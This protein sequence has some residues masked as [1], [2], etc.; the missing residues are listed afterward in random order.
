MTVYLNQ[1]SNH[2]KG[3]LK[4]KLRVILGDLMVR[5]M[6]NISDEDKVQ[7]IRENVYIQYFL[8]FYSFSSKAPFDFSLF[9]EIRKRIGMAKLSRISDVIY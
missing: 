3:A 5:H 6:Q 1:L 9:V 8:G 4:I 7:I 2:S